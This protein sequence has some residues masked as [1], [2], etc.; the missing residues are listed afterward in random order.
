MPA[1]YCIIFI[2]C[3]IMKPLFIICL[4]FFAFHFNIKAQD[5]IL[6]RNGDMLAGKVLQVD[7]LKI[8]YVPLAD[9]THKDTIKLAADTQIVNIADV[10]MIKFRNGTKTVFEEIE[11]ATS[12]ESSDSESDDP[13]DEYSAYELQE[14]GENDAKA[15]FKTSGVFWAS[16]VSGFFGG[17]A[18]AAFP[19]NMVTAVPPAIIVATPPSVSNYVTPNRELLKDNNYLRGYKNKAENKKVQ[20]A[21]VGYIAGSLTGIVTFVGIIIALWL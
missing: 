4:L 11:T 9:S 8:H 7:S 6:T 14:M 15:N 1:N 10:F 3:N 19:L 13:A 12:E 21:A 17:L 20:N 5:K 16:A 18:V 2:V